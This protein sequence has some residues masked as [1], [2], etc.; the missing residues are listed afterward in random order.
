MTDRWNGETFPDRRDISDADINYRI[1]NAR[2][3]QLLSFG[4]TGGPG[5]LN[6]VARDVL[7]TQAEHPGVRL[8]VRHVDGPVY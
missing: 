7:R 1:Y 5:A 6:S 4:S 8:H 2:T 3:G